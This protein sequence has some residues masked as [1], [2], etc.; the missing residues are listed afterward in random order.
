MYYVYLI[1]SMKDN[2]FYIGQTADVVKRL[3]RHNSGQVTSTKSRRPFK[4]IGFEVYKTRDEARW[5][6]YFM[7]KHSDR[8]KKFIEKL[9]S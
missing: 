6:E 3:A 4:L 5:A 8:K 1:Q 2:K 9:L 7:K